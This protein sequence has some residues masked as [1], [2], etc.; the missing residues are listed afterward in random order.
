MGILCSIDWN[1]LHTKDA[2]VEC[3]SRRP[4]PVQVLLPSGPGNFLIL[5]ASSI[6]SNR[7]ISD[8]NRRS[9]E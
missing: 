8:L 1:S 6:N 9:I 3:L 7:A 5:L 4:F 2:S